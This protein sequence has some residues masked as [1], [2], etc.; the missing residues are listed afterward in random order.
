MALKKTTATKMSTAK[1]P[2]APAAAPKKLPAKKVAPRAKAPAKKPAAAA[3][4]RRA[5]AGRPGVN[6]VGMKLVPIPAGSF[7]MGSP[8]KEKGRGTDEAQQ[9]VTIH[10]P[11]IISRTVV[12]KSEWKAVMKSEPWLSLIHI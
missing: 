11:F 5:V 4:A 10:H 2:A 8:I 7:T 6:S 1:K 12:T 3:P 9:R